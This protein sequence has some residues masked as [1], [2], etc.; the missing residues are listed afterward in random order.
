[1]FT[2]NDMAS[3]FNVLFTL[4][5]MLKACGFYYYFCFVFLNSLV[6][7]LLILNIICMSA[8]LN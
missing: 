3:C 1:M 2:I 7:Y 6:I 5:E 4:E 8:Q